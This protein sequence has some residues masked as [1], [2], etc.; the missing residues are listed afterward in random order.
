MWGWRTATILQILIPSLKCKNLQIYRPGLTPIPY[1]VTPIATRR[2]LPCPFDPQNPVANIELLCQS[3]RSILV[4]SPNCGASCAPGMYTLRIGGGIIP[5]NQMKHREQLPS[6]Q[7]PF[8]YQGVMDLICL[9]GIVTERPTPGTGC[10]LHCASVHAMDVKRTSS[11]NTT[12]NVQLRAE[13]NLTQSQWI[14]NPSV[15]L[16]TSFC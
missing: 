8:G 16:Y 14:G 2:R 10:Y 6:F 12:M 13:F 5:Y 3:D 7:C 4:V 15:L 11:A 9:D 1:P